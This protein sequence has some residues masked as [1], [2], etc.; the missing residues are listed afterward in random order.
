VQDALAVDEERTT[1]LMLPSRDARE[2]I[3]FELETHMSG[4]IL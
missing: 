4:D 3:L 1:S 2:E